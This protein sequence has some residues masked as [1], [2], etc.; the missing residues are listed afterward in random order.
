MSKAEN[1]KNELEK[2]F[3]YLKDK[4]DI[5]SENRI[6]T[7]YLPEEQ[8]RPVLEYLAK[9]KGFWQICTIS[10]MEEEDFYG[11]IY[12]LSHEDGTVLSL[13]LRTKDKKNITIKTVTEFYAGAELYE[14]EL[15]DMFGIKV[16]GLPE[17]N[18]YPLPDGWPDGVHPLRKDYIVEN[19]LGK[20]EEVK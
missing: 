16:E 10:G 18:R 20:K 6:F 8:F 12:H 3:D 4:I 5:K 9:E 15:V 17:G 7:N 2:K 19:D 13:K 11:A 14:R 1:Y